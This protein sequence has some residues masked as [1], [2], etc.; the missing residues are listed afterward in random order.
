MVKTTSRDKAAEDKNRWG[1]RAITVTDISTN[2]TD[3]TIVI[4]QTVTAKTSIQQPIVG[5]RIRD[6]S[7]REV[8]GTNTRVEQ[9]QLPDLTKGQSVKLTWQLPNILSDGQYTIDPA[10][11]HADGLTVADWWDDA[12]QLEIKKSRHLP[13]AIDPSFKLEL[14]KAYD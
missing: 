9:Q 10:I 12:L 11:L 7:G 1:D 14:G 4:H 2:V 3:E 6:A 5:F 8:T 13:Y